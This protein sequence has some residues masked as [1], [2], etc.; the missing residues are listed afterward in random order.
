MVQ[1]DNHKQ[2]MSIIYP[3][4][5]NMIY[6]YTNSSMFKIDE[7]FVMPNG[8]VNNTHS[9]FRYKTY[10][11]SDFLTVNIIRNHTIYNSSFYPYLVVI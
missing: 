7:Y 1:M 6:N 10:K 2:N 4:W 5:L 11:P 3:K 8:N 9:L